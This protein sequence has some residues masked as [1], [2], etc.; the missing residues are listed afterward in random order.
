MLPAGEVRIYLAC[1]VTDMRR[2]F[3]SLAAQVQISLQKDPY[4]GALYIFRGKRDDL[5][6]ILFWDRQGM[7]PRQVCLAT[8]HGRRGRADDGTDVDADSPRCGRP[9][10]HG[11][12]FVTSARALYLFCKIVPEH[13]CCDMVTDG[14]VRQFLDPMARQ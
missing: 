8:S 7:V 2:G 14:Q 12:R 13:V 9:Q 10:A 6:K 1:G 3:H 4:D 11:A 5:I